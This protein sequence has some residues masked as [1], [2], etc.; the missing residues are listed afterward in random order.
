MKTRVASLLF[1]L[2][3]LTLSGC[4]ADAVS[5]NDAE[6]EVVAE[7]E[8]AISSTPTNYGYFIVTRRDFRRCIAPLCG[9]FF[10]K[11][12]NEATTTCAD[13]SKQAE[14]YVSSITFNGM[15]LSAREEQE[16]RAA[17]ESGHAL[18]KARTYKTKWNGIKL[19]TLK[20][21]EGWL[22][23]TNSVDASFDGTFYRAADNGIRCIQA[24]CPSTTAF[25]LNSKESWNVIAVHLDNTQNPADQNTLSRAQNALSTPEGILVAGGVALPKCLPGSNCGPFVQASDFYLKY[26]HTE[27]KS[28]GGHVMG[29]P[30]HCN[31]GQYCAW[32]PENMCG[33]FDA[34]GACSY[35]P[36]V[37]NKIYAPVCACD[38]QTYSNDCMAAAAGFSVSSQGACAK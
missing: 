36:E 22:S 35:K 16:F 26:T 11:R 33:A 10:V 34:S 2:S 15:G 28:C 14:C 29:P 21:S 1:S 38:G 23:A 30:P 6:E 24:P 27:G 31:A 12:V 3:F 5:E 25:Q 8:D 18:M 17:V 37:C 9:G 20:A 7:S 19:G 13:G 32:T 4:A